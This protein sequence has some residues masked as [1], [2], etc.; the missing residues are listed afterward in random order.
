VNTSGSSALRRVASEPIPDGVVRVRFHK[1]IP[2]FVALRRYSGA[3]AR[4]KGG[5]L[6]SPCRT[7]TLALRRRAGDT[8]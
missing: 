5:N 2:T 3:R 6:A 7:T 1:T 8:A 4:G